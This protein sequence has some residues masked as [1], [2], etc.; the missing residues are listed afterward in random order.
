MSRNYVNIS[1]SISRK[2]RSG[3]FSK[4]MLEAAEAHR[5]KIL[6]KL[7]ED[8]KDLCREAERTKNT[9]NQTGAQRDAY[10]YVVCYS[11][12]IRAVGNAY[13]SGDE[14]PSSGGV[15]KGLEGTWWS[16]GSGV[17]WWVDFAE[18]L[19]KLMR[20]VPS[21]A[22]TSVAKFDLFILNA[23]YY[24]TWLEDGSY[25][26]GLAK[27]FGHP[28]NVK[29]WQVISQI[30]GSCRAVASKYGKNSKVT[31]VGIHGEPM[32]PANGFSRGSFNTNGGDL[33]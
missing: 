5:D 23:A 11:G 16:D 6:K 9:K 28:I 32:R 24:T 30:E 4:R 19:G 10:F 1:G 27:I 7:I 2:G 33:V 26:I 20:S 8:G 29:H 18:S 15:H 13:G 25:A 22:R 14:A 17:D 12:A 31:K 21:K 3:L